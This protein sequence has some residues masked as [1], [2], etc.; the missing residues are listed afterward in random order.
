MHLIRATLNLFVQAVADRFLAHLLLIG[1]ALCWGAAGRSQSMAHEPPRG[2]ITASWKLETVL[3]TDGRRL[4]GLVV[5]AVSD[6]QEIGF[7][8]VVRP[9]GKPMYLIAWGRVAANRID[10]IE[11][12][13]ADDHAILKANVQ[14]FRDRHD[15]RLNAETAVRLSRT[16]DDEPWRYT[17]RWFSLESSADSHLTRQA[18][19][20]LEQMF[21]A[22]ETLVPPTADTVKKKNSHGAP[23]LGP[24]LSIQL[25]GTSAEYRR[26]QNDLGISLKN[27]AFFVPKRRLLVAGS[28]MPAII[29]QE[30]IAVENLDVVLKRYADLDRTLEDGVHRL[31]ADLAKQ[32]IPPSERTKILHA[33]R[34]RWDREKGLAL[35]QIDSLRRENAQRVEVARRNFYG[36]LIHETWHAYADRFIKPHSEGGLPAWLDEGLAQVFETAPLEAGELR[37]D[38]PD[39]QRLLLLQEL[40]RKSDSL[41]LADLLQTDQAQFLVVHAGPTTTSQRAYLMAWGLAF[42]LALLEP[43][44]TPTSLSALTAVGTPTTD[45]T[46]GEQDRGGESYW[47]LKQF[48]TLVGMPLERFEIIWRKRMLSLGPSGAAQGR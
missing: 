47:A 44:L 18:I 6:A 11:R 14:A 19:V 10:S 42:H 20:R 39:P 34:S 1:C 24:P 21:V 8:Q 38:A 40:L 32:G 9:P 36:W 30:K 26:V 23:S 13:A 45:T 7:V 25:C 37:M 3:L 16:D 41:S 28:D 22:L 46:T 29:E 15:I 48:E 2:L 5:D 33:A 31:L 12:L 17:G 4:E 43:V 35:L 27:P